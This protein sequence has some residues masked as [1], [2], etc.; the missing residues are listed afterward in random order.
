MNVILSSRMSYSLPMNIT[1]LTPSA[2]K[3]RHDMIENGYVIAGR[4]MGHDDQI[5]LANT[6]QA[7]PKM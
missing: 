6:E 7:A 2:L 4:G 1:E 5:V 3:K